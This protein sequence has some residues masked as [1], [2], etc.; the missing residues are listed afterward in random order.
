[1]PDIYIYIIYRPLFL[2]T[3]HSLTPILHAQCKHSEARSNATRLEQALKEVIPNS[4]VENHPP[5]PPTHPRTYPPTHFTFDAW[6]CLTNTHTCVCVCCYLDRGCVGVSVF[7]SSKV[8][9]TLTAAMAEYGERRESHR[10]LSRIIYCQSTGE[11][12]NEP[13]RHESL[14]KPIGGMRGHLRRYATYRMFLATY[15]MFIATVRMFIAT[16]RMFICV[17]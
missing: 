4:R 7:R 14:Q 11:I 13:L 8:E 2:F 9:I 16:Y 17:A 15:R 3:T 1:M 6:G 5:H 12:I 10:R